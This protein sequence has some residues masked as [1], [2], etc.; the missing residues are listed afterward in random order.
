MVIYMDKL[1]AIVPIRNNIWKISNPLIAQK[2]AFKYLGKSGFLFLSNRPDKK[3][4]VL[5][6]KGRAIHFGSSAYED[7]TKH[8]DEKR[9]QNYLRRATNIKGRWR[10]D[11]YS[12]NNLSINIL[13]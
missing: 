13:W 8:Q 9:R 7:H 10:E 6:P 1:A 12:P 5:D 4:M 3:Y 11:N 2:K